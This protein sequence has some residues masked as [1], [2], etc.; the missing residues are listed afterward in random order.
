[1]LSESD[2]LSHFSF[3]NAFSGEAVCSSDSPLVV[4]ERDTRYTCIFHSTHVCYENQHRYLIIRVSIDDVQDIES[5]MMN[6]S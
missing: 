3:F 2:T 6:A 5:R 1:M 4:A